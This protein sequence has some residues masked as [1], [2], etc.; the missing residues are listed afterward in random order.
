MARNLISNCFYSNKPREREIRS[1]SSVH[2][3]NPE[4]QRAKK[5]AVVKIILKS[6]M[7]YLYI[8]NL[9]VLKPF[10]QSKSHW[11]EGGRSRQ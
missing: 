1:H 11:S 4:L 9:T 10:Y 6:L 5:P 7:P 8:T 2:S 3:C